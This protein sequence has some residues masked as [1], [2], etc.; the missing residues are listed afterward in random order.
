[1]LLV[2]PFVAASA[3]E[4]Q[5]GEASAPPGAT[6]SVPV[7]VSGASG[8]VAAQFDLS[9]NPSTV[10]LTGVS[11]GEALAGHIVDQQELNPGYWRV[12]AYST[13]NGPIAPGA[14]VR[15]SF[16]IPAD[17][18]DG[19]IPLDVTNAI[20]AQVQGQPVRPLDQIGGALFVSSGA[21]FTSLTLTGNGQLQMQFQG[22]EGRQYVIEASTNLVNWEVLNTNTVVGGGFSLVETNMTAYP[23]RFYRARLLP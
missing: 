14:M 4:L 20:I 16:N 9:F 2:C 17:A 3:A 19:L 22:T 12:L 10:S 1:M 18:P 13:T 23:H 6:V 11:A 7:T 15:L 5:V 8:A 21:R